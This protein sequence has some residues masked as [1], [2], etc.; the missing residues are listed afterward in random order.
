MWKK[1]TCYHSFEL[2]I[3]TLHISQQLDVDGS[4]TIFAAGDLIL[5]SSLLVAHESFSPLYFSTLILHHTFRL[6]PY[7]FLSYLLL[8]FLLSTHVAIKVMSERSDFSL[9]CTLVATANYGSF[10][11]EPSVYIANRFVGLLHLAPKPHE[12]H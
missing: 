9:P 6:L 2:I 5:V 10:D 7:L 12:Q 8:L 4:L 3:V 1:M 11:F